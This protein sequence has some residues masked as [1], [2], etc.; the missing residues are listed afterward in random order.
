[1]VGTP[2]ISDVHF[3][4]FAPLKFKATFEVF[5]EV[6]LGEYSNVEVPYQDPQV[7]DEDIDK[8][9]DE[10]R[11]QKA[12]YVN[13]DPRPVEDGDFAVVAL[14]S[15]SGVEGEPVK[16]DEMVLEIGAK[17]TFEAF[18]ENLRGVTP[19]EERDF[20]V[21]YPEDYGSK[22][23]PARLSSSTPSCRESAARNCPKWTM[24]SPRILAITALSTN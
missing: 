20:E 9:I 15:L 2:D 22:S 4:D 5:P 16:T 6:E 23:W 7:T 3:H 17:D 13:V 19:G 10:I 12:Q 8:R 21:I 18:T 11:E 24:S 14:E 1:M